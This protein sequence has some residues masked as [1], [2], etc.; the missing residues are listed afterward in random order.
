METIQRNY[1]AAAILFAS[2]ILITA[3]IGCSAQNIPR[4][5]VGGRYEEGKDQFLRGRG[6]DMDTA[7]DALEFVVSKDPAYKN[8]LMYL[9]RAYYRKGR[10]QDAHAI[11][12][13]AL[14]LDQEDELAWLA[15]G[16]TQLRIG[17]VDK[18]LESLKGGITLASRVMVDGYHNYTYWDT[19]G[20]IR[21]SIRRSAF[22]LTKGTEEKDNVIQATDRLL[23]VVD[24]EENFQKTTY[25]QSVRPL[26]GQ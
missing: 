9:G 21:A 1:P 23:A 3:L 25:Q 12:Q 10:Y 19:R 17:Q 4:F 11:L 6:G 5:G 22:L 14:A 18:G 8:S 24:E 15:F 7:I 16:V 20:L 13:R 2:A 26:Y